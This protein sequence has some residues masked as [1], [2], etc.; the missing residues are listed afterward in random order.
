MRFCVFATPAGCPG[1]VKI[2][3][4]HQPVKHDRR[5]ADPELNAALQLNHQFMEVRD[6]RNT[7]DSHC[8]HM[9]SK[10]QN[11]GNS[12]EQ[13][14]SSWGGEKGQ[15]ENYGFERGLRGTWIGS[16]PP[17]SLDADFGKV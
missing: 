10:A 4:H 15:R 7:L 1:R 14:T 8:P 6:Q 5:N 16:N 9:T 2:C 12:A 11:M 17:T 3:H 13:L